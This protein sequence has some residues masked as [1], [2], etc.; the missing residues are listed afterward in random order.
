MA[1]GNPDTQSPSA[2]A[3]T[4]FA[5][6]IGG[7]CG[8]VDKNQFPWIEIGLAFEPF[9]T[10]FSTSERCCSEACDVFF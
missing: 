3:T 10:L 8:F 6:H 1:V 9:P 2:P 5:R 7:G 4:A